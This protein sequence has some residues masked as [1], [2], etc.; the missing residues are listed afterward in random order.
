ME[1][2]KILRS[3]QLHLCFN[4][5]ETK[6]SYFSMAWVSLA[7]WLDMMSP[8]KKRAVGPGK[9]F[10]ILSP[11][12]RGSSSCVPS[13]NQPCPSGA[14]KGSTWKEDQDQAFHKKPLQKWKNQKEQDLSCPFPYSVSFFPARTLLKQKSNRTLHC[15]TWSAEVFTMSRRSTDVMSATAR[16]VQKGDCVQ[17]TQSLAIPF[18][19]Q[20]C[21]QSQDF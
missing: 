7:E 16:P 8:Q 2:N 19:V 6:P 21:C 4:F 13:W 18:Y 14:I 11:S 15:P 10:F 17:M 1:R 9:F 5:S 3:K 20:F 12:Q